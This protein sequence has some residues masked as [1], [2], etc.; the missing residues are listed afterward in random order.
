MT[1][2]EAI[3][4]LDHK[5]YPDTI[6][7]IEYYAGFSSEKAK[8]LAVAEACQ[9]VVSALRAQKT[10]LY[11]SRWEGCERC[12]YIVKNYAD[13]PEYCYVCGK[14]LTEEAW[15]EME[16]RIGGNNGTTDVETMP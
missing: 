6:A 1:T 15:A 16:R 3:R 2:E 12:D 11:R 8:T 10:K 13:W 7:E 5:T 4:L 14:P 9:M